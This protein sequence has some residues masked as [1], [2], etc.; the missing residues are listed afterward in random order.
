MKKPPWAAF[1]MAKSH[2]A[3]V[4]DG[5][6]WRS[7]SK[8]EPDAAVGEKAAVTFAATAE[9]DNLGSFFF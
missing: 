8:F 9:C 7:D 2:L 1:S 6:D 4:T 5:L 3:A